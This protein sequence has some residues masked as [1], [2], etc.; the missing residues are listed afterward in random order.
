MSG[1]STSATLSVQPPIGAAVPVRRGEAR[2][3]LRALTAELIPQSLRDD[4]GNR[5]QLPGRRAEPAS[6]SA[7]ADEL[8][9][10][11]SLLQSE[12]APAPDLLASVPAAAES[13]QYD[14]S[15][16]QEELS[17]R[18][19][20]LVDRFEDVLR[21]I[22]R[23]I[24]SGLTPGESGGVRELAARLAAAANESEAAIRPQTR[25]PEESAVLAAVLQRASEV[26]DDLVLAGAI[27]AGENAASSAVPTS[28]RLR[29]SRAELNLVL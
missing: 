22:E 20:D 24:G 29:D 4:D 25:T 10:R 26:F 14:G 5:A 11:V 8:S 21:R 19:S 18:I 17:S 3:E 15:E 6:S 27:E 9:G 28:A 16:A 1:V 23:F 7:P 12:E 13:Q 2:N